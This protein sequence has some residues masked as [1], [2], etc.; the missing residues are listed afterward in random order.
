MKHVTLTAKA[1]FAY[2]EAAEEF[3]KCLLQESTQ[4]KDSVE[5]QVFN[6]DEKG[7]LYKNVCE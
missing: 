4:E 2:Q 1:V 5:G 6:T 7:L 3:L